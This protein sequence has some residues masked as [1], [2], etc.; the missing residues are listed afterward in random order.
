MYSE[1]HTLQGSRDEASQRSPLNVI[2]YREK[3][4]CWEKIKK[5]QQHQKKFEGKTTKKIHLK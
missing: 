2:K 1:I 4:N 3:I 5:V